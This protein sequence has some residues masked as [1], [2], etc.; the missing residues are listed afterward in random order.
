MDAELVNRL[1]ELNKN[2]YSRFAQEFSS[3]RSSSKVNLEPI[4]PYLK[5][6]GNILDIGCGNGRL[7]QRLDREKLRLTY[8]GVDAIPGL[9]EIAN[10]R[11]EG[12]KNIRA[13]FRVADV[14]K[15]TWNTDLHDFDIA[16]ALAVLHHIPSIEL[17]IQVLRSLRSALKSNG[18]L[19][20]TNWK[21][22]END[23]LRRKIVPWSTATIDERALEPGDALI[24]WKRGGLGYRYVHLIAPAEVEQMSR[25]AGFKIEQQFYSDAGLNLLS[26][27]T[28]V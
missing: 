12:M 14:T 4:L 22:D 8:F 16:V 15:G 10:E 11:C 20:M 25:Q 21:F 26:V 1:I 3:T 13:S 6:G 24:A 2:F 17:R 28:V 7:A 19:I 9:V 27:L 23:R 5:A 18:A